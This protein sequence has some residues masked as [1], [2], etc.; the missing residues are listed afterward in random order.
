MINLRFYI[1]V[2]KVCSIS[3]TYRN[4]SNE[5]VYRF[6]CSGIRAKSQ[7]HCRIWLA[8]WV[9]LLRFVVHDSLGTR[10]MSQCVV[11]RIPVF[12]RST[13][14]AYFLSLC[15][16]MGL[17]YATWIMVA[18]GLD[19]VT[20]SFVKAFTMVWKYMNLSEEVKNWIP[21]CY[22]TFIILTHNKWFLSKLFSFITLLEVYYAHSQITY[23]D[24]LM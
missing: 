17:Q 11:L 5:M 3:S 6:E 15:Q 24:S 20:Q 8:C 10:R 23:Y 22:I 12:H 1:I 19:K 14:S 4:F 16:I 13:G 18:Q 21:F 9:C 2:G 7:I